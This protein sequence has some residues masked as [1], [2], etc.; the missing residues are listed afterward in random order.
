MGTRARQAAARRSRRARNL[1]AEE[2]FDQFAET[3]TY[4]D[5]Y[6]AA[7]LLPAADSEALELE[8][9]GSFDGVAGTL[10]GYAGRAGA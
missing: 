2:L 1:D 9:Q 7:L 5:P 10:T 3:T 6:V 8:V 4:T